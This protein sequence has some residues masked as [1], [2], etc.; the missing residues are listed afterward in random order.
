M[1]F[2]ATV[3]AL[4]STLVEGTYHNE[5]KVSLPGTSENDPCGL[6]GIEIGSSVRSMGEEI[7]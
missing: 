2:A 4:L 5:I 3:T 1:K 7:V 6:C